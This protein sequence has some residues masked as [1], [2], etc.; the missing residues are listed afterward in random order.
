NK[1]VS[2]YKFRLMDKLQMGSLVELAE[3]AKRNFLV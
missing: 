2:T 3:L 1:T